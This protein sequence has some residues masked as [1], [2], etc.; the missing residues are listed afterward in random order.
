MPAQIRCRSCGGRFG[1]KTTASSAAPTAGRLTG[2]EMA[3]SERAVGDGND[4]ADWGRT[5]EIAA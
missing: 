1:T 4:N 2:P 5:V 3:R